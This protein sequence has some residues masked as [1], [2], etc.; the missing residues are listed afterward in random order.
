MLAK[1]KSKGAHYAYCMRC[2][3]CH[4]PHAACRSGGSLAQSLYATVATAATAGNVCI[5]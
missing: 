3:T 1:G 4:M 5:N 2:A